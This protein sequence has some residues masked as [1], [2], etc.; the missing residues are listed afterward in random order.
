MTRRA[1]HEVRCS[2]ALAKALG[3]A[4]GPYQGPGKF[5]WSDG[6]LWWVDL[7]A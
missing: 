5:H 2:Y 4:F 7:S 1:G 6:Y 3:A